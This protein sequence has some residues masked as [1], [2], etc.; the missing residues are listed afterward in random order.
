MVE[1]IFQGANTM[2]VVV[3][4][5]SV[6]LRRLLSLLFY[7]IIFFCFTD[8]SA[9]KNFPWINFGVGVDS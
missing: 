4:C 1:K 5:K 3:C 2:A 9:R 6:H 8:V 7:I